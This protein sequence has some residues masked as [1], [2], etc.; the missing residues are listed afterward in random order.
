MDRNQPG[1]D[2]LDSAIGV[3]R[4]GE[5]LRKMRLRKKIS[6]VDLGRHTGLSP[7]M[8][9]QLETG[10]LIPTLPTLTR[11]AIVFDVGL[12]HFFTEGAGKRLFATVRR[13]ERLR[14]PE[15]AGAP[16]PA[17]FFECLAFSTQEKAM[18]AYMAEFP[19]RKDYS[20]A[21][22]HAGSEFVYVVAGNVSIRL[23]ETGE[24]HT[25]EAGDS[26]YFDASQPHGYRG[27]GDDAARAV[28][29]THPPRL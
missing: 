13:A 23:A 16:D 15:R 11:I 22:F 6:L 26:A 5:K 9:S 8:L 14:F 19:R 17:Y 7:S 29:V 21:H 18:E 4:I 27:M 24:E 10:K 1:D 3:Y 20:E 25:L 12:D 28:I 2:V